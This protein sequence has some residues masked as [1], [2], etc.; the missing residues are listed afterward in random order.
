MDILLTCDTFTKH[1]K[2]EVQVTGKYIVANRFLPRGTYISKSDLKII[3]GRLD[4]LP[5]QTY[6][7]EK[8]VIKKIALKNIFPLQSIT[9]FMIRPFW[10]VHINQKVTIIIIGTNFKIISKGTALKNGANNELVP[11][12]MSN[13]H[14]IHGLVNK[15]GNVVIYL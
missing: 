8:D 12:K 10:L 5:Y 2:T 14:I 15:Y 4:I 11:I 9:S 6:F 1:L 13:N 7:N 3:S